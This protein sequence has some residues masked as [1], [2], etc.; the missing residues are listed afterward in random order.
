MLLFDRLLDYSASRDSAAVRWNWESNGPCRESFGRGT[1]AIE[2]GPVAANPD[3]RVSLRREDEI[4][5]RAD[6]PLGAR[7]K[8]E[9]NRVGVREQPGALPPPSG[10]S[11]SPVVFDG[12]QS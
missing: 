5:V 6:S 2:L 3:R 11:A 9:D 7:S 4:S 12:A 10:P 8:T 1:V